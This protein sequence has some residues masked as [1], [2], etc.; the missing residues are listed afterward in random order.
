[1][2]APNTLVTV[3]SELGWMALIGSG[4]V[5]LQLQFGHCCRQ[6]AI[7]AL[8][9]A[10]LARAEPGRFGEDLVERLQAYAS[11]EPVDF[12]NVRVDPGPLTNFRRQ[13]ILHCRRI[14]YG[15]TLTYGQLAA[16][17]GFPRAARAV[18][19]CMAANRIPLIIPCHRVTA[20]G[21]RPGGF[22]A[23]GGIRTKKRLLA[24]ETR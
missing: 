7:R 9:P 23:A 16:K 18:G 8:D 2:H 13:V 24:M 11:G 3:P 17:A 12:R 15:E 6:A 22:S 19:S 14:C 5:L 4:D 20:V 10:L 1:M 21:G